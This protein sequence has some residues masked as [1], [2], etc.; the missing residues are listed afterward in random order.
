MEEAGAHTLR[1]DSGDTVVLLYTAMLAGDQRLGGQPGGYCC[2]PPQ[3]VALS[4]E[5]ESYEWVPVGKLADLN[6]GVFLEPVERALSADI[7]A[8]VRASEGEARD[9]HGRWTSDNTGIKLHREGDTHNEKGTLT[10]GKWITESGSEIP[11]HVK[12]L[13][14]PPAWKNVRVAPGL[15]HDLQAIGEDSKGRIQRI[16]SDEATK[17]AADAKFARNSE[18]LKKQGDIFEQNEK[19]LKSEDFN[20]RENAACMKLIQQTGIRPGSEADTGAEKKAYGAT[21]LE[22][23]HIVVDKDFS[24]RLKFVGKNG[25]DLDIPVE[26]KDLAQMLKDRK[27]RYG[28]DNKLFGTNDASLRD[29]SH[30]LDGGSFKPKDFRTLKGTNTA[31]EEIDKNPARASTFKE[32]K[33]RVMEI[34][35]R[36]SEK[37]GNT[38]QIALQSYINPSVF[39]R[40]QPA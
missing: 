34:A 37:L 29:Y 28:D 27:A 4:G 7:D 38:P 19:N 31:I 18:L 25:V 40:I 16:Y 8:K 15:E 11:E 30:K 13:G 12:K 32:Y 14:I 21:T 6:L 5:H 23:R 39:K 9:D 24:V 2:T 1:L 33:Q 22:G 10:G 3:P 26:D 20:T 36:V 17:K 35:K